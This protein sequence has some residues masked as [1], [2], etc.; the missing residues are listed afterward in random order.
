[1][2][3]SYSLSKIEEQSKISEKVMR[4]VNKHAKWEE[5]N[6]VRPYR[7]NGTTVLLLPASKCNRRHAKAYMKRVGLI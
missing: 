1:M 2:G 4:A 7:I 5:K 3:V 6:A